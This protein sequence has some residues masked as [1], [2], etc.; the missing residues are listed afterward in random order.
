MKIWRLINGEEKVNQLNMRKSLIVASLAAL[1]ALPAVAIAAN[2]AGEKSTSVRVSFAD[3]DIS[4]DAGLILLYRR[5]RNAS[6][7]VCGPITY[8]KAG[9]LNRLAHNK[10]CYKGT[11]ASAVEKVGSEAL[12]ELHNS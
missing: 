3:L 4:S 1:L 8:Q 12:T 9:N 7:D 11:L 5:L 10:A 6:E 2:N